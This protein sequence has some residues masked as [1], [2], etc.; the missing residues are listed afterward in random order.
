MRFKK[1]KNNPL[2]FIEITTNLAAVLGTY[3]LEKFVTITDSKI[4]KTTRKNHV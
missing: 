1:N 3:K 2:L 4:V